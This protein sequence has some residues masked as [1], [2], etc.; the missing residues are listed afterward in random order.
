MRVVN[1]HEAKSKLLSL[2]EPAM[3]GEIYRDMGMTFWLPPAEAALSG[4]ERR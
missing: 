1:M 4:V 3:A 2:V